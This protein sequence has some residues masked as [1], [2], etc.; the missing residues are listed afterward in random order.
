MLDD[1]VPYG[2]PV[3]LESSGLRI[4]VAGKRFELVVLIEAIC[5]SNYRI[6]VF[7]ALNCPS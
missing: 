2:V 6:V 5:S 1:D 4:E 3:T 7:L